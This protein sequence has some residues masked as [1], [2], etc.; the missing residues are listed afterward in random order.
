MRFAGAFHMRRADA[1]ALY[2]P[3]AE[4]LRR[5]PDVRHTV[6]GS[7]GSRRGWLRSLDP[8]ASA[9]RCRRASGPSP[10]RND[11]CPCPDSRRGCRGAPGPP[12]V[13]LGAWPS[14][15]GHDPRVRSG[16]HP[17]AA[18][19]KAHVVC[20]H[21][22]SKALPPYPSGITRG[23]PTHTP[24][25]DPPLGEFPVSAVTLRVHPIPSP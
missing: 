6:A 9:T 11:S 14:L 17:T 25:G 10:C 1:H 20:C 22:R 23:A 18:T 13:T 8:E 24:E 16:L 19:A 7:P 15:R 21:R 4:L 5:E 12:L 3:A 2:P